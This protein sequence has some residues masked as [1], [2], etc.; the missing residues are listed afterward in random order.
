MKL[1]LINL[2]KMGAT[3]ESYLEFTPSKTP[4]GK[5]L[6]NDIDSI[7]KSSLEAMDTDENLAKCLI[8]LD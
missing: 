1:L 5:N 8:N 7:L 6:P 2:Y 3:G 4:L